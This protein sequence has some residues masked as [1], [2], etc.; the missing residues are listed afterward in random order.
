[1][2]HEQL[3]QNLS[4]SNE[5]FKLYDNLVRSIDVNNPS[6]EHLS[7][8]Y[9]YYINA[10]PNRDV[11]HTSVM[12][13]P[14]AGEF[15]RHNV[16][17]KLG[18]MV[19]ELARQGHDISEQIP[20]NVSILD[21]VLNIDKLGSNVQTWNLVHGINAAYNTIETLQAN[22]NVDNSECYFVGSAHDLRTGCINGQ[23]IARHLAD[24]DASI[25]TPESL[26]SLQIIYKNLEITIPENVFQA[27]IAQEA[28]HVIAD[29]YFQNDIQD[30]D[31]D[32]PVI[33]GNNDIFDE[34]E[35]FGE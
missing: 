19:R 7:Q 17:S 12:T 24:M 9:T 14:G 23:T 16:Q 13:Q 5:S 18:V 21:M 26:R 10:F 15:F 3:R 22:D 20:G 2:S 1:M 11:L 33:A 34:F 6:A 27:L 32:A 31:A 29:E 35:L 30:H 25:L 4:N 28:A 8:A